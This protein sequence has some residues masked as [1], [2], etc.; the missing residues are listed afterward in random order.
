MYLDRAGCAW[1]YL[2][3]SFPPW[4]TVYGYFAA[5][6]DDGTLARLHDALRAQVRAAAGRDPEPTAAIIDSQSVRAADTVPRASR[7]WDNAKKVNGRKRHI[8]VDTT[9]LLLA[10]VITAACVQDRD[11]ARPLLWNLHRTSRRIR[12]I[13]ADSVYNGK[14]N[15]W[16]AAMK[17]TLQI[18]ARRQPHAFEVLP[19][20]W[21]VERTF[22]W[23]S[24]HRRTVRDY[25]RLPASHEAMILWAMTAL[26]ARRL[27]QPTQLSNAHL[28]VRS[29]REVRPQ[30][31]AAAVQA[32]EVV[33]GGA[34]WSGELARIRDVTGVRMVDSAYRPVRRSSAGTYIKLNDCREEAHAACIRPS[35]PRYALIPCLQTYQRRY[36][37]L[38]V[39]S[40]LR[41]CRVAGPPLARRL[42]GGKGA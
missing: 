41:P 15:A 13:W 10:V 32:L 2:P 39:C 1:R 11:A 7:G 31:V 23:I 26:M 6:R 12:L 9:G 25:E 30:P 42:A 16:A 34:V 40:G 20:R 24:K 19:R 3:D 21:V 38:R 8:A 27:T 22:A 29:C 17:M 18:V 33:V 35:G 4:R 5:W 37:A 28:V 36:L 14:L